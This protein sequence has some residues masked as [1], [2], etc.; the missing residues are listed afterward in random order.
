MCHKNKP[1]CSG[2]SKEKNYFW[3]EKVKVYDKWK[4]L[5]YY[6]EGISA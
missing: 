6:L 2:K 5:K 3:Q 1:I 4:R